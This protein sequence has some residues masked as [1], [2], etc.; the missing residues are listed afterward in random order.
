MLNDAENNLYK[1]I[2]LFSTVPQLFKISGVDDYITLDDPI[3]SQC[4]ALLTS[5][6]TFTLFIE[7][8]DISRE[9]GSPVFKNKKVYPAKVTG[10]GIPYPR[11]EIFVWKE[12]LINRG[13]GQGE[14]YQSYFR[15]GFGEVI[16][17]DLDRPIISTSV[18]ENNL[19]LDLFGGF[20]N[21][22][23]CGPY[24]RLMSMAFW[25]DPEL[26]AKY[27]AS[28]SKKKKKSLNEQDYQQMPEYPP[29]TPYQ[30]NSGY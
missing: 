26:A 11:T 21:D 14:N 8:W 20:G 7:S 15:P 18:V 28:N 17:S 16:L 29:Y 25:V 10:I 23:F 1:A 19:G 12:G 3:P 27:D 6:Y 4:A 2:G 9:S 13:F 30:D 22:G 24:G 5:N